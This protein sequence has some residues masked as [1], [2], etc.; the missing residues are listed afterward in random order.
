MER[1]KIVA[2]GQS[3][4][5]VSLPKGWL[6]RNH[7]DQGD[8]IS[9][10][11]MADGS[12]F[13]YPSD[14][15]EGEVRRIQLSVA[16]GED[17]TSIIRKI[18]GAYMNGYTLINL[19]SE[20]IFAVGQQAAIRR[21][22]GTLYLMTVESE[23]GSITL[24]ALIDEGRASVLSGVERMHLITYSMFRD[25]LNALKGGD[26]GLA[27][28]AVALE[29]D[30]DQLMFFLLRLLRGAARDPSLGGRLGLDPLDCL[31]FQ[32]LVQSIERVADHVSEVGVSVVALIDG[33]VKLPP[34][35]F[36]GLMRAGEAAFSSYDLAVRCFLS[37][38]VEPTNEVI[39]GEGVIE[40]IYREL[41]PLPA[42]GDALVVGHVIAIREGVKRISQYAS[43]VAELTIDR[44]YKTGE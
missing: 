43:D 24:E 36:G 26:R 11:P 14:G 4:R 3:S 20:R 10:L 41:T 33:G 31:E 9:I 6:R 25:I 17:D 40:E 39:D 5:V 28:S 37:S 27:A 22:A 30:V 38:N 1:R 44:A 32:S 2:L 13:L 7:L 18:I 34:G 42:L 19:H 35:V 15:R 21:I 12:L 29:N 8:W 23:A 16:V